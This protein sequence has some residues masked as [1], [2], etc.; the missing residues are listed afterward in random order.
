MK[1]VRHTVYEHTPTVYSV[2]NLIC[3]D[4]I[5]RIELLR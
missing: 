3:C 4:N 2:L 5:I 1:T